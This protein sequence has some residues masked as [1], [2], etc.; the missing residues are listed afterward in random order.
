MGG[1]NL[2]EGEAEILQNRNEQQIRHQ[3]VMRRGCIQ[4]TGGD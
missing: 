1:R 2:E 3:R 4:E